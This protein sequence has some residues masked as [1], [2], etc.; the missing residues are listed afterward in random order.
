M[1]SLCLTPDDQHVSEGALIY[2]WCPS[3]YVWCP[4]FCDFCPRDNRWSPGFGGHGDLVSWVPQDCNKETVIGRLPHPSNCTDSRLKPPKP[5]CERCLSWSFSL[6][7]GIRFGTYLNYKG[8]LRECRPGDTIFALT[9]SLT[10][11]H[12]YLSE[13]NI[14]TCLEPQ[15]LWLTLRGHLLIAWLWWLVKLRLAVLKN[16]MYMNCLKAATW[17]YGFQ[18]AW[19]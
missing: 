11:A 9:F 14:Y 17:G 12:W 18:S 10:I 4:G 16:S 15:F 19:A 7:A 8:V 3:F 6:G 2:V 13:R 5:F 1:L